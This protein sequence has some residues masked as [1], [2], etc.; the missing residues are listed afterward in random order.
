[1]KAL[2]IVI[3]TL[4]SFD[5]H[6]FSQ[7][8]V[9]TPAAYRDLFDE[10]S[11][12]Q[13][14]QTKRWEGPEVRDV[15]DI[16]R[17]SQRNT[18]ELVTYLAKLESSFE[19]RI[20][21]AIEDDLMKDLDSVGH[22]V[23]YKCLALQDANTNPPRQKIADAQYDYLVDRLLTRVLYCKNGL[24]WDYE[25]EKV[26]RLID[27]LRAHPHKDDAPI[28]AVHLD[29]KDVTAP[30][31]PTPPPPVRDHDAP[32]VDKTPLHLVISKVGN[33]MATYKT[34]NGSE[35]TLM[36]EI[37][38]VLNFSLRG[39]FKKAAIIEASALAPD[40][41]RYPLSTAGEQPPAFGGGL[42]QFLSI[43]SG[44]A[45]ADFSIG[46]WNVTI[47]FKVDG[48]AYTHNCKYLITW[49]NPQDGIWGG[50]HW[51]NDSE[52]EQAGADQPATKPAEKPPVKDQPS[53]PTS[54]DHPR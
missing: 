41:K 40:G 28:L 29:I 25:F 30:T 35:F 45:Y 16:Q 23:N 36:A 49:R 32:R 31:P 10:L 27:R 8:S 47:K 33:R 19:S 22:Y 53:T 7:Q 51:A 13:I 42:L 21:R 6:C 46:E 4:L 17:V 54:K 12:I 15:V 43:K 44:D 20:P 34:E 39:D 26:F 9:K 37:E 3:I 14:N 2:Q 50:Q 11:Q 18:E 5:T 38:G 48:K 24:K 52:A 1:M